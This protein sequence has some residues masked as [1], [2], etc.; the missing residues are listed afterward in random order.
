VQLKPIHLF[1][2]SQHV[3]R[4]MQPTGFKLVVYIRDFLVIGLD[5]DDYTMMMKIGVIR[6]VLCT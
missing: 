4:C 5:Y 2:V 6:P 1:R 3:K